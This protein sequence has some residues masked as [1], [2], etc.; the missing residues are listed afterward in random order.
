M[1]RLE[2][3]VMS[4]P[5]GAPKPFRSMDLR[6]TSKRTGDCKPDDMTPPA[7]G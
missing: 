3:M 2:Q 4:G 5:V 1:Q 6:I 7:A